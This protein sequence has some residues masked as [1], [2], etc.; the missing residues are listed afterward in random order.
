MK[1]IRCLNEEIKISLWFLNEE[2]EGVT[3][4]DFIDLCNIV[5]FSCCVQKTRVSK[6][7]VL[8]F[9]NVKIF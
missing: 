3:Q 2:H 5:S 9:L 4:K 1:F 7:H 8:Q 6:S